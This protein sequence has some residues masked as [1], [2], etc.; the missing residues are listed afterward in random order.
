[1]DAM[2]VPTPAELLVVWE[3][4]LGLSAAER[5]LHLLALTDP[6]ATWES[7]AALSIG[8]RDARLLQLRE[9]FFGTKMLAMVACPHC[10]DPLE[11]PLDTGEL[12]AQAPVTQ[13]ETILI[14][15]LG[16]ELKFRLPNSA[17]LLWLQAGRPTL[18]AA[19][20]ILLKR[21][22]LESGVSGDEASSELPTG[23][24]E[25]VAAGMAEADPLADI[26]L[27]LEC[28]R[29]HKTWREVF[30]IVSFLWTEVEAWARRT[31]S[32]VHTLALAYGWGER[33]IL[34]L[35]A[36]RRQFYLECVGA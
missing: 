13:P 31:L 26:Q 33:E 27:A 22:L 18:Q 30:D 5:A 3:Y 19:E 28:P 23:V 20:Q 25:A 10:Q 17:D 24:L 9:E 2:R 14:D 7:L 4:G 35:S 12:L 6:D 11:L 21:C 34:S 15:S 8:R 16:L 1:M 36:A 29:C 32:E